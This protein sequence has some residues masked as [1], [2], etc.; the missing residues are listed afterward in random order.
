MGGI[1]DA[2][3]I[4][5]FGTNEATFRRA[6]N[7]RGNA[8]AA[9]VREWWETHRSDQVG[10]GDVWGIALD[11]E[12]D[13]DL[14]LHDSRVRDVRVAFGLALRAQRGRQFRWVDGEADVEVRI[15][16]PEDA[17]ARKPYCLYEVT[18]GGLKTV[19]RDAEQGLPYSDSDRRG[20]DTKVTM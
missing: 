11:L 4:E 13:G 14:G 16:A 17:P 9:L 6:R 15:E 5:G 20:P 3:G 7:V 12:V 8:W 2:V 10:S 18:A 1:L 19:S